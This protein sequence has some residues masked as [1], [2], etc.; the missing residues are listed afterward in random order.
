[1]AGGQAAIYQHRS[2]SGHSQAKGGKN[3]LKYVNNKVSLSGQNIT[4][5]EK[6]AL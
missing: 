1:M 6:I 5:N 4:Q 3:K 2:I